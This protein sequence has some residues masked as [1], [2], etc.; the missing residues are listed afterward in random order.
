MFFPV[1]KYLARVSLNPQGAT[2]TSEAF[3]VVFFFA[4][5]ILRNLGFAR[6]YFPWQ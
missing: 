5:E 1:Q 4:Y 3:K 2:L 6:V